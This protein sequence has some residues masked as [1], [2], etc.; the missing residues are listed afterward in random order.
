MT[1]DR[2]AG[3]TKLIDLDAVLGAVDFHVRSYRTLADNAAERGL[4]KASRL[5]L[6]RLGVVLGVRASLEGIA[7]AL[8]TVET[9]DD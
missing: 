7:A 5:Y 4:E 8:P 9:R 1:L 2:R 6:D 3:V